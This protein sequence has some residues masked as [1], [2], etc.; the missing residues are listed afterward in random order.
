MTDFRAIDADEL[1]EQLSEAATILQNA[2]L[3]DEQETELDQ[4]F[5]DINGLCHR[6]NK[7]IEIR[8]RGDSFDI[9]VQQ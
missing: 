9:I 6:F 5:G 1:H 8:D 2:D 3:T 4:I 7:P